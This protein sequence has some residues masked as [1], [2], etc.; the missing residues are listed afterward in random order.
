MVFTPYI[1]KTGSIMLVLQETYRGAFRHT[2]VTVM[3]RR[4]IDSVSI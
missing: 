2:C 4:G 3:V 1:E